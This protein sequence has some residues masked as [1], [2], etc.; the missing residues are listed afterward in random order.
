MRSRLE[1][2]HA[3]TDRRIDKQTRTGERGERHAPAVEDGDVTSLEIGS[4]RRQRGNERVFLLLCHPIDS[5][6]VRAQLDR[7]TETE[8]WESEKE[9]T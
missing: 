4:Y 3:S 9:M 2:A 7:Q 5:A 8:S 1:C 6:C